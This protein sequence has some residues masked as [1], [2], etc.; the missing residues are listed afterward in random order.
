MSDSKITWRRE[1]LPE[2]KPSQM[3][4]PVRS[5][6]EEGE[7][8][9]VATRARWFKLGLKRDW[10]SGRG[11]EREGTGGGSMFVGVDESRGDERR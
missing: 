7:E 4:Q 5:E 6:V 9:E 2:E 1:I 10:G 3:K 8:E 11:V